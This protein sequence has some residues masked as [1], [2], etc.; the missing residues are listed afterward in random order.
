MPAGYEDR[1]HRKPVAAIEDG[2][3]A[4]IE[5]EVGSIRQGFGRGRF[6]ATVEIR[7]LD[8]DGGEHVVL[9]RWF[10]RVGGLERWAKGGRVLAVGPA[11][12]Y[13]GQLSLAHPELRDPADPG[14]AIG[15]R[16]PSVEGVAP[17]TLSRVVRSAVK[18]L[19]EA[20]GFV[21]AL[22]ADIAADY[23]L[24]AV[25]FPK[26]TDGRRCHR[27]RDSGCRMD[28]PE[29]NNFILC[30]W[31]LPMALL[32]RLQRA[33][34]GVYKKPWML[35]DSWIPELGPE[36]VA[37]LAAR[38]R[39]TEGDNRKVKIPV[40]ESARQILVGAAVAADTSLSHIA[41]HLIAEHCPE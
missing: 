6:L 25:A 10:H 13:K 33:A 16:Y 8:D 36:G 39:R 19:A 7:V 26:F 38:P 37:A 32:E 18:A 15:V 20:E 27:I 12:W 22:P 23:G 35:F 24:I 9:A 28:A 34:E 41:Q 3:V 17:R 29:T 2:E 4:V 30:E 40:R 31:F 5:G 14:P 1:R 21:D 11:R